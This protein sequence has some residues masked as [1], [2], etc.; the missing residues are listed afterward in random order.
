M[1]AA[2]ILTMAPVATAL[3]PPLFHMPHLSG[4]SYFDLEAEAGS[5]ISWYNTQFYCGWGNAANKWWYE[6]VLS[7]GW[8]PAI[9]V[10]GLITSPANGSGFV[11]LAK[12]SDVLA[13]LY[14]RYPRF[15]GIMGWEYFNSEPGGEARPWE[16]A[17]VMAAALNIRNRAVDRPGPNTDSR[18]YTDPPQLPFRTNDIDKLLVLGFERMQAFAALMETLGNVE[19]AANILFEQ[20]KDNSPFCAD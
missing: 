18:A 4:F 3:L 19:I 11:D 5:L 1:G 15:G 2:F 14:T 7:A 9:V 13:V 16:W 17:N 12:M 20:Q 10:L 6:A 8:D